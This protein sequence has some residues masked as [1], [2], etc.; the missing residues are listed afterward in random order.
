MT[1]SVSAAAM[2]VLLL[3]LMHLT[4]SV[5][6]MTSAASAAARRGRVEMPPASM[7]YEDDEKPSEDVLD[8]LI[9]I[10]DARMA[11]IP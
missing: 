6:L 7:E 4:A 10:L 5:A 8:A 9:L 3:L 1:L 2:A 11:F